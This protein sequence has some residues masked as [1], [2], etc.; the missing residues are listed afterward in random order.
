MR[1]LNSISFKIL[2][3]E[4]IIE[5]KHGCDLM[6]KCG[7]YGA[8][9]LITKSGRELVVW[10]SFGEVCLSEV[11]TDETKKGCEKLKRLYNTGSTEHEPEPHEFSQSCEDTSTLMKG[12]E[13]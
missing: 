1:A 12:I 3:N 6:P 8:T 9:T 7:S 5:V 11:L 10:N 13:F 4:R 2:I